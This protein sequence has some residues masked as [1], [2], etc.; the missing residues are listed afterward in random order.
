MDS[1]ANA[2]GPG[3]RADETLIETERT[4]RLTRL[5]G[6]LPGRMAEAICLRYFE[7]L[8]EKEMA[9]RL[10]VPVGTVKSRLHHGIKRL[11]PLVRGEL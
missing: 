11:A 7:E 10:G 6:L 2:R 3:P 1:L 8:S 5:I 4:V 9:S